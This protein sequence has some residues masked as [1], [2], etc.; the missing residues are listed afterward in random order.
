M[1]Q[2]KPIAALLFTV[3]VWGITPVFLRSLSVGLGP[4]DA[5]VIRYTPIALTCILILVATGGWRIARA[6]W[7]RLLVISCIGIFIYSVASVYGFASVPAGIGGLLYA[8]QPLFIALLAA[9]LLGERLTIHIIFGFLLAIAG[10][11]LLLW[12]DLAAGPE[13]QS[14]AIGALLLVTAC[15]A[16]AFYSVPGKVLF[17]R[18]GTLSMTAM[19]LLIAT[20]PMLAFATPGTLDTVRAMTTRHWLELAYLAGFSTFIAMFTWTYGTARVSAATSG[21]FLYLIPVIAVFAGALLLGE[22]V[23]LTTVLGGLL[24]L[25]GVAVAQFGHRVR[26]V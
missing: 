19:S 8:T 22:P 7:P 21:A 12:K 16:W 14:Y 10:T 23:M 18:Y 2:F 3:L 9:V 25:G 4:A 15:A 26:K 17:Q 20:L 24:I 5:L 13:T 1:A 6:D 11:V